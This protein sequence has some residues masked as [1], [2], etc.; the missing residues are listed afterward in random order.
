MRITHLAKRDIRTFTDA[1][2]AREG[3]TSYAAFLQVWQ[4]MHGAETC[5]LV[6]RFKLEQVS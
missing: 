3:F 6:I 2:V 4:Q 5:A 1:D